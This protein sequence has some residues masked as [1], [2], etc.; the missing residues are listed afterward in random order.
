[1]LKTVLVA[2]RGEIA[3][4][5]IKSLKEMN[6]HS[7][8][9]YSEAD[10]ESLHVKMA[11]EAY[12]IG[13]ANAKESYL[14]IEK[15]LEV[16]RAA[17]VDAIHPG[18]GFLS[19]NPEFA[20]ACHDNEITFIGPSA[21]VIEKMGD[22]V[23]ARRTMEEAGV[24]VLPGNHYVSS[25]DEAVELGAAIGYPLMVK[26]AAGG[27]GIG[28]ELVH[29]DE[30]LRKAF[31]SNQRRASNYFG[32]GT[33]YLEKALTAPRHIEVQVLSDTHGNHIHLGERD[34][35]IQ[36]RH[37]KVIE[38]SPAE[39]L[40]EETKE[41]M[42]AAAI[43]A[44]QALNYENAG[45]LE[46]LVEDG[47]FYFLE[48]NT[49]LQVEHPVTE[50]VTG[51]DIVREQIRIASGEKLSYEQSDVSFHGHSME[52]RVYAEDPVT[53]FPSPGT[54]T[55]LH[56]PNDIR[57][58]TAI[59]EGTEVTPFYDPMVAKM[60]VHGTDREDAIK[61]LQNAI[62]NTVIEGIKTNL[63]FVQQVL[64]HEAFTSFNFTTN[65]V[66]EHIQPVSK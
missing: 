1:M 44:V 56:V 54:I 57:V 59:E 55:T 14:S 21:L 31:S 51:I 19:E 39:G 43:K 11:D 30:E 28:M 29:N 10:Q 47:E 12:P 4:R 23:S 50:L 17:N 18:Y 32:S 34:C 3:C 65:F 45:T 63:P 41:K 40:P 49:R 53:F 24:P 25:A 22:K 64:S 26:A 35:S 38:E 36:R 58:D 33:L 5:I 62:D 20:R 60:V 15:I 46:F 2:N 61:K 7:V 37:Q 16:S 66:K 9:V 6:I 13:P 48:M 42:R 8:A 52:C 27:G